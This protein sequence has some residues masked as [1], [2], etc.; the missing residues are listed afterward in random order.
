VLSA[1]EIDRDAAET[2]RANHK[3]VPVVTED[4]VTVSAVDLNPS[5][6]PVDLLAGCAPCQGFCSL[7]VKNKKDDPRNQLVLEMGRLVRELQP[8][9]VLM[10][11]VPGLLKRGKPLF[12]EFVS[13][14][15]AE[16]YSI[17]AQVVQMA[18]YGVPQSR[19]R[20]V[21]L[22]GR[23]FAIPFPSST[24]ARSPKD[25]QR[26][27]VSVR[28][29]LPRLGAP[30]KMSRRLVGERS[31]GLGWHVVRDLQPQ[32]KARLRAA[33][34]GKTWRELDEE[35]RPGCHQD[36]YVG[37]TNVYGR[38]SWNKPSPTITAGCTTPA[39]GRF[40]H[41]DRR[42]TTI[43]VREA[44][45][46]QTFPVNYTFQTSRIDKVCEMIGNAVPPAFSHVIAKQ[47]RDKLS[48]HLSETGNME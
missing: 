14:L 18:D 9:A 20:L 6:T 32:T 13:I 41:P 48:E 10:E 45:V 34:P 39:K 44:A 26:G 1:V 8:R 38:M 29:A 12:D 33:I 47:I 42:R 19:R 30:T 24:H 15:R 17:E 46:L 27:W 3:G 22:A 5:G 21:L 23:G 43:S 16:G 7:T 2:Y 35:L 28:A 36:G 31:R 37:F 4:I 40:G 11:N 25:G